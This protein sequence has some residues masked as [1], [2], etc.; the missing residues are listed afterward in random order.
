MFPQ[1][2]V[3][4]VLLTLALL[5]LWFDWS[6]RSFWMSGSQYQ[7]S[8][9]SNDTSD[10]SAFKC[11]FWSDPGGLLVVYSNKR[12]ILFEN[13]FI[14]NRSSAIIQQYGCDVLQ[15]NL[16]CIS[17]FYKSTLPALYT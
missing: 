8:K 11:M 1:S 7:T 4:Y 15:Q 13:D 14:Q 5:T 3:F 10:T 16:I 12:D 9:A 2:Y 6:K 17:F